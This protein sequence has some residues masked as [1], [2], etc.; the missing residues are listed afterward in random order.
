MHDAAGG[1]QQAT[2]RV[3]ATFLLVFAAAP[4]CGGTAA[5]GDAGGD[6]AVNANACSAVTALDHSCASDADCVAVH[7]ATN[8]CGGLAWIGIRTSERQRFGTLE[9]Q[10]VASYPACGCY[11]G[12][13]STDDG[14]RIPLAGSAAA[15][16]QAGVCKTYASACGR[17]CEAG[18]SCRTCTDA[19]AGTMTST[20][21]VQCSNDSMCDPSNP[22]CN[23]GFT[24]GLC[25]PAS[26][27]CEPPN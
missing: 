25:A 2:M 13:D 7:H 18:S 27:S 10:C 24:S 14:S 16:C 22:R 17:L 19:T 12:R 4:A 26:V 23:I 8:C 9:A 6:S 3:N 11:D 15:T 20:C 1:G 21:A 5:N